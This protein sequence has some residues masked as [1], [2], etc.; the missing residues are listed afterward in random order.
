LVRRGFIENYE[1]W[2]HQ[3]ERRAEVGNMEGCGGGEDDNH[4]K[5]RTNAS[6]VWKDNDAHLVMMHDGTGDDAPGSGGGKGY[7]GGEGC[8]GED[9]G[10]DNEEDEEEDFLGN[11]E[12]LTSLQQWLLLS[13][14]TREQFDFMDF[15][16]CEIEDVIADAIN[17]G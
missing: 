9:D 16:L 7:G 2:D 13:I 1:I 17:V 12:S 4:G 6:E 8:G 3:G 14:W 15:M 5:R 11:R 10:E